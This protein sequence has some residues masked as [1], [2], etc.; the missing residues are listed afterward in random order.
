MAVS[1]P[2][3]GLR[4]HRIF[5]ASNVLEV[6]LNLRQWN[7]EIKTDSGRSRWGKRT[8]TYLFSIPHT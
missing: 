6:I 4:S 2:I 3:A 8:V 7:A 5:F 1:T